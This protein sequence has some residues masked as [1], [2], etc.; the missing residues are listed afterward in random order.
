MPRRGRRLH[1]RGCTATRRRFPK[2]EGTMRRKRSDP[3]ARS[4]SFPCGALPWRPAPGVRGSRRNAFLARPRTEQ[5]AC[6]PLLPR[7]PAAAFLLFLQRLGQEGRPRAWRCLFPRQGL[8]VFAF[9]AAAALGVRA[10]P[11]CL[12][13]L[14]ARRAACP[15]FPRSSDT[16][17]ASP[18]ALARL[19]GGSSRTDDKHR[20]RGSYDIAYYSLWKKR[21]QAGAT[22]RSAT[23]SRIWMALIQ[24]KLTPRLLSLVLAKKK[25]AA[26][27]RISKPSEQSVKH[28]VALPLSYRGSLLAVSAD[29][30]SNNSFFPCKEHHRIFFDRHPATILGEFKPISH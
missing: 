28:P 2:T 8:G 3:A 24:T 29:C 26:P 18:P 4:V 17:R 6:R 12:E 11:P 19:G 20:N 27:G 10:L 1:R 13:D 14:S 22:L 23:A 16:E 9:L 30:V 15:R 7:W 5:P 25:V 21:D